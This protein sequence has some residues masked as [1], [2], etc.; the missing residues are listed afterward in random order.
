MGC[1]PLFRLFPVIPHDMCMG[2]RPVR[3]GRNERKVPA[4]RKGTHSPADDSVD[5]ADDRMI[6]EAF[7][8]RLGVLAAFA[9][10]LLRPLPA[11]LA[12]RKRKLLPP[13]L[14]QALVF[15]IYFTGSPPRVSASG[16][17]P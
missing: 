7:P 16:P 11:P 15:T 13:G 10:T 5:S 17:A 2:G 3:T 14:G 4:K 6:R 1:F 9:F 12:R 8:L